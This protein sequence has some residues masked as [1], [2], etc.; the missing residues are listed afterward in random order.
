MIVDMAIP[1]N[2]FREFRKKILKISWGEWGVTLSYFNGYAFLCVEVVS[3]T[4]NSASDL[5]WRLGCHGV[6][7]YG[8]STAEFVCVINSFDEFVDK[9]RWPI[10]LLL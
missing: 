2:L 5:N 10:V 4:M 3:Q 8:D 7:P 6:V 9:L 1:C